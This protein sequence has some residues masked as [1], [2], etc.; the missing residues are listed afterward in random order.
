MHKNMAET[1]E[2]YNIM[3]IRS[4]DEMRMTNLESKEKQLEYYKQ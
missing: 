3:F 4:F 2:K 1:L